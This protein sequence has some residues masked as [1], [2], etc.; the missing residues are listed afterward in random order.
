[1]QT[2]T[3]QDKVKSNT[4]NKIED[5]QDIIKSPNLQVSR[6]PEGQDKK[7][8]S[9]TIFDKLMFKIFPKL[10]TASLN[11]E[12]NYK[13]KDLKKINLRQIIVKVLKTKYKEKNL[14]NIQ[15]KKKSNYFQRRNKG[16]TTREIADF[17]V[18][19]KPKSHKITANF[20]FYF[21]RKI[22]KNEE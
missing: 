21:Q 19:T 2:D 14:R 9:G 16:V 7:G 1:M 8:S 20:K 5:I 11:F 6:V 4:E 17:I 12:K 10:K 13:S 18:E 15:D 22:S 3:R